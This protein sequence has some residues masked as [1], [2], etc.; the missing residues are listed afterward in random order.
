MDWNTIIV[1][2]ITG[3]F[4]LSAALVPM[5]ILIVK[6]N[7]RKRREEIIKRYCDDLFDPLSSTIKHVFLKVQLFGHGWFEE[8]PDKV[9]NYIETA[10]GSIPNISRLSEFP[11]LIFYS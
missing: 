1:A 5:S 2:G 8:V 11:K 9:K 10:I 6:E 4:T 3:F 7:R